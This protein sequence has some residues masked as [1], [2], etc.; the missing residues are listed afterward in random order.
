MIFVLH[1]KRDD[2]AKVIRSHTHYLALLNPTN[3]TAKGFADCLNDALMQLD[4]DVCQKESV[5]NA[6]CRPVLIGGGT[7]GASIN[8]G[9]EAKDT[10]IFSLQDE[11]DEIVD[12]TG[13]TW[14]IKLKITGRC[15]TNYSQ[16]MMQ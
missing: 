13:S 5:Q 12:F 6:E 10:C 2:K 16:H 7:D 4:I 15:G 8:V 9:V 11:I 3:F 14:K 1:C